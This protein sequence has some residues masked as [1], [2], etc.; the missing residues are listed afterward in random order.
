MEGWLGKLIDRIEA[1][2]EEYLIPG[3]DLQKHEIES[4]EKPAGMLPP[5]LVKLHGVL[6]QLIDERNEMVKKHG[7]EHEKP[8]YDG[9]KC[10]LFL[11]ELSQK[12]REIELVK[13][14]F[15]SSVREHFNINT[16]D[17]KLGIRK[18]FQVVSFKNGEEEDGI[19]NFIGVSGSSEIGKAIAS[20]IRR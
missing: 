3:P 18:D 17:V 11:K 20:A 6:Q 12:E 1:L 13:K 10:D 7:E 8:D 4:G 5:Y 2:P 9:E 19:I 15:W 14:I 16:E